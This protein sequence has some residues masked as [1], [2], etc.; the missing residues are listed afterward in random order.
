MLYLC[1]LS[2]KYNRLVDISTVKDGE[3]PESE[4]CAL[5]VGE[6]DN[7]EVLVKCCVILNLW[8]HKNYYCIISSFMVS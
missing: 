7:D 8:Y 3:F 5:E 4:K 6:E 2:Y 1:S